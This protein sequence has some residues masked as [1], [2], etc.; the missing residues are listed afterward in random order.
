MRG[1][2]FPSSEMASSCAVPSCGPDPALFTLGRSV[3]FAVRLLHA[4]RIPGGILFFFFFSFLF[5]G[6]CTCCPD[7][8]IPNPVQE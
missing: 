8:K 5:W 3:N 7:P 4:E 2:A 1:D 6:C